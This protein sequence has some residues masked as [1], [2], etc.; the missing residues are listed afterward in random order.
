MIKYTNSSNSIA[1]IPKDAYE[2]MKIEILLSLSGNSNVSMTELNEKYGGHNLEAGMSDLD[3]QGC[4][5][6]NK[7]KYKP[8]TYNGDIYVTI[9][10]KESPLTSKAVNMIHSYLPDDNS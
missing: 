4:F 10:G 8:L 9:Y 5:V 3:S 1:D 6:K 7:I 2:K